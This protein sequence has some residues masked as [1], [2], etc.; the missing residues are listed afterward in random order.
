MKP[1]NSTGTMMPCSVS[2]QRS[3]ETMMNDGMKVTA[4]GIIKVTRIA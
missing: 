3:C 2:T 1:E 4:G